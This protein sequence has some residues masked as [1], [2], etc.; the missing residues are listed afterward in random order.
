MFYMTSVSM[1][2]G[3]GPLW[4]KFAGREQK[5][6]AENWWLGLLMLNNYVN[7]EN[8]VSNR[9]LFILLLEKV[10]FSNLDV[11]YKKKGNTRFLDIK[12]YGY[13]HIRVRLC[14]I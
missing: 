10:N 8:I 7:A 5:F 6:C 3:D 4:Q 11:Y 1:Y 14:E 9:S 13:G 12:K 2:T